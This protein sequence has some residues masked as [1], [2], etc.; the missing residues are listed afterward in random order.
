MQIC[1]LLCFMQKRDAYTF[2]F[3]LILN[4][5]N[6]NWSLLNVAWIS[7]VSFSQKLEETAELQATNAV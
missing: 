7:A 3:L 6:Q 2:F 4:V 5:A 1:L